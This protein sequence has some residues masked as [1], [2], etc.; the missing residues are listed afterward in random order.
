MRRSI[1]LALAFAAACA[2]SET[3]S[4]EGLDQFAELLEDTV[5][6]APGDECPAG[7]EARIQGYDTNLDGVLDPNEIAARSSRCFSEG[8]GGN[9]PP[10]LIRVD[11][12]PPGDV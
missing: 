8:S 3:F 4:L 9:V 11:P 6:I 12:E 2:R 10:T 1:I 5:P 7:G